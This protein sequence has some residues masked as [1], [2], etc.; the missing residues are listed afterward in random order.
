[1]TDVIPSHLILVFFDSGASCFLI[2]DSSS[3]LHSNLICINTPW[4]QYRKLGSHHLYNQID[5]II[6]REAS[7]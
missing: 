7:V 3:A 4:D 6:T 5:C 1:M 2:T